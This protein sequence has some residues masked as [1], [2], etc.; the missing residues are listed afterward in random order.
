MLNPLSLLRQEILLNKILKKRRHK[1]KHSEGFVNIA[2][3]TGECWV[4]WDRLPYE[5][6]K[7]VRAD[8]PPPN[9]G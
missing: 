8:W 1:K 7:R 2:Q 5:T 3:K 9:V 6:K 4:H